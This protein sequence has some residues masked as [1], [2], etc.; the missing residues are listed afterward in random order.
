MVETA[1]LSQNG[2]PALRSYNEVANTA[3]WPPSHRPTAR[4][5]GP[6]TWLPVSTPIGPC[7][8]VH[9][10]YGDATLDADRFQQPRRRR[11]SGLCFRA[12]PSSSAEASPSL[13]RPRTPSSEELA[14]LCFRC[15]DH[16]L[17]SMPAPTTSG[18]DVI[19]SPAMIPLAATTTTGAPATPPD[20]PRSTIYC[21]TP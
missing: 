8:E 11:E 10:L 16:R 3:L 4:V 6:V 19:S 15:L 20:A 12:K 1:G 9:H 18:V 21:V 2:S 17:V 13:Q 14:G 7:F 5:S